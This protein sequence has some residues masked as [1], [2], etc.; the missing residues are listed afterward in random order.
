MKLSWN[1]N[2][3]LVIA[4]ATTVTGRYSQVSKPVL[5]N[6]WA[7]TSPAV[8]TVINDR[9]TNIYSLVTTNLYDP[10]Y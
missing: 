8:S 6:Y 1:D 9:S 10:C 7:I 4:T 5:E 2:P 3:D